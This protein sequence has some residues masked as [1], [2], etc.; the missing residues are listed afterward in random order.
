MGD[1]A[2]FKNLTAYIGKFCI[3]EVLI[4]ATLYIAQLK[5]DMASSVP[6][7]SCKHVFTNN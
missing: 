7:H 3:W 1:L 2:V 5:T 6:S 4:Q